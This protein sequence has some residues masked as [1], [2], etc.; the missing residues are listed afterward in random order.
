MSF[1]N[2][3]RKELRGT[4]EERDLPIPDV[5]RRRIDETLVELVGDAST[6]DDIVQDGPEQPL[7]RRA[8]HSTHRLKRLALAIVFLLLSTSVWI[9]SNPQTV[10]SM[11]PYLSSIFGWIGDKGVKDNLPLQTTGEL[12]ILAEV[13]NNGYILRIHEAFYDGLQVS[14]TYTFRKEQGD[15]P[16]GTYV[17]P[18][19]QLAP[20]AKKLLGSTNKFDHGG[21]YDGYEAGVVKYFVQKKLPDSFTLEVN[22]PKF[23]IDTMDNPGNYTIRKGD[24]SFALPI[25]GED[26]SHT[27]Q[28]DKP[29]RAEQEKNSFEVVKLRMSDTAAEWHLRLQIPLRMRES[30][31]DEKQYLS[32]KIIDEDGN[33]LEPSG[34]STKGHNTDNTY[35]TTADA[36]YIEDVLTHTPPIRSGTIITVIP[37]TRTITTVDGK[38]EWKETPLEGL[39]IKVPVE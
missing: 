34:E 1:E 35:P 12:P 6:A 39:T 20:S 24:W 26:H 17:M 16:S 11:K 33:M 29:L 32:Y 10:E 23:G 5:V 18:D 2:L 13:K 19:F 25:K 7:R 4:T 31:S 37:M 21:L 30:M 38:P 28:W 3:I 27:V 9:A 15:I 22:V 36:A 8:S 14:F